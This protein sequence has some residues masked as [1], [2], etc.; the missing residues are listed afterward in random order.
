MQHEELSI[1]DWIA[2]FPLAAARAQGRDIEAEFITG[3]R[4]I[5]LLE[6]LRAEL[7]SPKS[8]GDRVPTDIFIWSLTDPGRRDRT[9]IG[10]TPYRSRSKPWPLDATG[11]PRQFL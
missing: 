5:A 1:A 3:P 6:Q 4:S 8:I 9:Q 2:H 7:F 11:Q 10:G